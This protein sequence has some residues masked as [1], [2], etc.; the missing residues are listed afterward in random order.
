MEADPK[1][2]FLGANLT[3]PNDALDL[4][5]QAALNL[6]LSLME[7]AKIRAFS[8]NNATNVPN[9]LPPPLVRE[10]CF[11]QLRMLCELIA[12]GCLVAHSDIKATQAKSFQKHGRPTRF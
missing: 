4:D 3:A 10:Y 6:Y 5:D 7:E 2:R 1:P 12:L 9:R 8:I 11:L